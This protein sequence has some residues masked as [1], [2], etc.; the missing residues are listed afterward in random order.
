VSAQRAEGPR[1]AATQSRTGDPLAVP[2]GRL[3]VDDMLRALAPRDP[4]DREKASAL[5]EL[6]APL[7][8]AATAAVTTSAERAAVV[9][10]ALAS[11]ILGPFAPT[12]ALPPELAARAA[13]AT[14]RI[15]ESA[16]PGFAA[17]ARHPSPSLRA[18]AAQVLA[19]EGSDTSTSA[20]ARAL[21]QGDAE[22]R[23][24]TLSAIEAGRPAAL[25]GPVARALA[26]DESWAVRVRAAETLASLGTLAQAR[27]PAL[28]AL[29]FAASADRFALVREATLRSL[30]ALDPARAAESLRRAAA[31]DA[32]PRVRALAAEL[33]GQPEAPRPGAGPAKP[34]AASTR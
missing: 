21:E 26:S 14:R 9:G 28:A 6:E 7:R 27:E 19:H 30:H 17:L 20:L 2:D 29:E 4:D 31:S 15:L 22:A 34:D 32:E 3:D 25:V 13:A 8:L 12:G 33:L 16:A 5:I 11:E 10:D 18:R 23:R 24:A 1:P